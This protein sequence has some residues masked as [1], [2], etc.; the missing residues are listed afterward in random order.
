M[1]K[2]KNATQQPT[3][4]DITHAQIVP[5]EI[6]Y[7]NPIEWIYQDN[8]QQPEVS[9]SAIGKFIGS[10]S[11]S[12]YIYGKNVKMLSKKAY[13]WFI[14]HNGDT[15]DITYKDTLE[16]K[17][18]GK[19]LNLTY[20]L[21][22]NEIKT[23]ND[24]VI[25]SNPKE[26]F[27][28]PECSKANLKVIVT[29]DNGKAYDK[30]FYFDIGGIIRDI[31]GEDEYIN[32]ESNVD[33]VYINKGS[34]INNSEQNINNGKGYFSNKIAS[35]NSC[36]Q[37]QISFFNSAAMDGIT[38]D[39]INNKATYT[40]KLTNGDKISVSDISIVKE[41]RDGK[42][43]GDATKDFNIST[44]YDGNNEIITISTTN[45]QIIN[46]VN[47]TNGIFYYI[48][49]KAN[50]SIYTN[51]PTYNDLY[52]KYSIIALGNSGMTFDIGNTTDNHLNNYHEFN[53]GKG[54]T[55]RIYGIGLVFDTGIN[56]QLIKV[57]SKQ[58]IHIHK[59]TVNA[60]NAVLKHVHVSYNL[61]KVADLKL[62]KNIS[63]MNSNINYHYDTLH[64]N[65]TT[66]QS[67]KKQTKVVKK[68]VAKKQEAKKNQVQ[69]GTTKEEKKSNIAKADTIQSIKQQ[70]QAKQ[71]V[72][73]ETAKRQNQVITK[74][75][76]TTQVSKGISQGHGIGI[77]QTGDAYS[78]ED[79]ILLAS[80]G[81]IGI[82]GLS[83]LNKKE[84]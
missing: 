74:Q 4:G 12:N 77:G 75:I 55:R 13:G 71:V 48:N 81:L 29:Y 17:A 53:N 51:D 8:G 34:Y 54:I 70:N 47:S 52:N 61:D 16:D 24:F 39:D 83:K 84:D 42:D 80:V 44:K 26:A 28:L 76:G 64:V 25:Y 49:F 22:G 57:P 35:P 69:I 43:L 20:E 7:E 19:K 38:N 15:I 59:D 67:I 11:A 30:P 63:F 58:T 3:K 65:Q 82:I 79:M 23:I 46:D 32:P 45:K 72:Q 60:T 40:I 10:N 9:G 21:S 56:S 41:N 68:E 2:Y 27:Y 50:N 62:K 31:N 78:S 66:S 5:D 36:Y 1:N 73:Q 14:N 37:G 18:T 33:Q 6:G